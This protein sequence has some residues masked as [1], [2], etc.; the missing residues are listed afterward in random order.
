MK[1]QEEICETCGAHKS[2]WRDMLGTECEEEHGPYAA[3]DEWVSEWRDGKWQPL[4][5]IHTCY[6]CDRSG[7]DAN[8]IA[9]VMPP[10]E[11]CCDDAVECDARWQKGKVEIT[12]IESKIRRVV[13]GELWMATTFGLFAVGKATDRIVARITELL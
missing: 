3:G 12:D 6:F 4:K 7:S 10:R 13:K 9:V 2:N 5:E 1:C 8:R 11:Y